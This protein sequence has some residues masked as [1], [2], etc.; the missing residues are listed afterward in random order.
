MLPNGHKVPCVRE[1]IL[2]LDPDEPLVEAVLAEVQ[3]RNLRPE[4]PIKNSP[5]ASGSTSAGE[6][7]SP[8]EA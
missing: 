8:D 3:R 2:R 7:P 1:N 6:Q 5:T 4:S